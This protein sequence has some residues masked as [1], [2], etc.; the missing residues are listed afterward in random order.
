[1]SFLETVGEAK[2]YLRE[3]RRVS[4]R[5]LALEFELS[6]ELLAALVEELTEIQQLA[7]RD[8]AVLLWKEGAEPRSESAAPRAGTPEAERRQLTVLFCDLVDS[9]HLAAGVDPED[10]RE[11]VRG[12]Q[13]CASGV[14][15]AFDGHV[16]QFLGDGIMVYFGFPQAHE[17]DPERAVRAALG[18][19]EALREL[20]QRLGRE[21][22][23]ELATRIGIHTGPVVV[24]EV[25]AGASRETLALG[26]TTNLAARLQAEAGP[27]CVAISSETLRLV[28]GIFV[29]EELGRRQLKGMR[30]P[31]TVHRVIQPSGVRSLLDVQP[32]ALTPFI[33]RDQELGLL[34]DRWDQTLEQEGQAVLLSGEAGVGKSRL[35]LALRDR[36]STERHTWLECRSSPYTQSSPF[37]PVVA[38]VE[39][40]LGVQSDDTPDNRRRRIEEGIAQSGLDARRMVPPIAA[41]LGAPAAAGDEQAE[42]SPEL[43]RERTLEAL[44]AWLL[45]LGELQPV[46]L[47]TEDLHWC[48][49]SSLE[50]LG[51][52]MEQLPTSRVLLLMT[53]RPEFEAPWKETRNWTSIQLP[54]LRRRQ[55]RELV[56]AMSS[57]QPL[58]EEAISTI[59]DRADGVALYLEELSRAALESGQAGAPVSIPATLQDSLMARLDRL[60]SA[61]EVAHLGAVLGRE[62]SYPLIAA[63]SDL[64]ESALRQGLDRLVSARVLFRRGPPPD[65]S[66]TFKHAL[67]HQT[68]YESLLRRRRQELHARVALTLRERFP[69]RA[70]NE[71]EELGRHHAGA[72]QW[73]DAVSCYERAGEG[74]TLRSAYAEAV[75]HLTS[76]IELLDHVPAGADRGRRE[77]ALRIA[78]GPPL[79]G[80]RG[81]GHPEVE[82]NYTRARAL[83]EEAGAERPLFEAVWGLANYHQALGQLA[84]AE[85][86]GRQLVAMAAAIGDPQLV[87]WAHLQ[88]GATRFWS[89]AYAASLA[90]LERAISSYDREQY[91]FLPGGPDPCVAARVYAALCLWQLGRSREAL[92]ASRAGIQ[93][94]R[95][96][97]HAFSLG[98]ALCFTGS[99]HQLRGDAGA[100]AEVAGEVIPLATDHGFPQWRG[101]GGLVRGWSMAHSGRGAEGLEQMQKSLGEIAG[102]SSS[103]GGPAAMV[104]L[105]EAQRASG[106]P[107]AAAATAAGGLL[108]AEREDQRAWDAELLRIRGEA[109]AEE[110]GAEDDEALHCLERALELGR[111]GA[112]RPYELR[113]ASGLARLLEARGRSREGRETLAEALRRFPED[114]EGLDRARAE[115]QLAQ[116]R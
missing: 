39:Q 94:A 7:V 73:A 87:S 11:V 25:G 36:L 66:Y 53:A 97:E 116:L 110:K 65:A 15:D 6:E 40:G 1:M 41:L 70:R 103:L 55:A 26:D 13:E 24:G 54:R 21:W 81:Y 58:P 76:G 102:T 78:L 80:I 34:L 111:A 88:L 14:V 61:K 56:L 45:A 68:A 57:G 29:T 96:L 83:S 101:W 74:S 95:E 49:P 27:N 62:F 16:A 67:I 44:V 82:H 85:E 37:R 4:L 91:S 18:I 47:L 113:A 71:P 8:G 79:I 114:P 64:D 93:Q 100:A 28:R 99:L 2:A 46:V 89:G 23:F 107:G 5:A 17:D 35:V 69:E 38:L 90:E 32:E 86:L 20:N 42:A 3:H 52:L 77:L 33:G 63:V 12:Y 112:S 105:A 30:E 75:A 98:I 92:E 43:R 9:T 108:L 60:S 50:L 84:L 22:G 59:L 104:M 48:D 51:R 109:L 106:L 31:T 115:A 72:E 19:V 10:W